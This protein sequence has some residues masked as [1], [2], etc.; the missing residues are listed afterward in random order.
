MT[1]RLQKFNAVQV[2]QIIMGDDGEVDYIFPGS[3]DE[4][5]ALELY[6][7]DEE[8]GRTDEDQGR[9]DDNTDVLDNLERLQS[10]GTHLKL[11]AYSNGL[12]PRMKAYK[13]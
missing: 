3:D 9:T 8:Q 11:V 13:T 7:T 2:C 5:D 10:P 6:E 4:L 12:R 1:S